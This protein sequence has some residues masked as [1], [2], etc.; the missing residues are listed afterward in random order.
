MSNNFNVT[1]KESFD[2]HPWFNDL[3]DFTWDNHNKKYHGY[4]KTDIKEFENNYILYVEVP[5]YNKENINITFDDGYLTISVTAENGYN[6]K[7]EYVQK[8]RYFENYTRT[9]YV[10]NITE[11]DINAS[12]NN[13][14][15]MIL[16]PKS[17]VKTSKAHKITIN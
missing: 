4:L 12:L 1:K 5:G 15:L 13:G 2:W 10:G 8:E 3:W 17:N 14:V 6:D 9:Y 7:L 11:S 16:I